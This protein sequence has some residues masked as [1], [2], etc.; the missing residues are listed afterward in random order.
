VRSS[1]S[2]GDGARAQEEKRRLE[3]DLAAL[4]GELENLKRRRAV[5]AVEAEPQIKKPKALLS[6]DAVREAIRQ[7]ETSLVS[8]HSAL[9][10]YVVR[11]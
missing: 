2:D 1:F 10:S 4:S 8:V 7:Q 11:P 6:A 9:S 5:A 3:Q